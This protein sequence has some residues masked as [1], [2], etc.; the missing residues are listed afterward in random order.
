MHKTN[1]KIFEE[2]LIERPFCERKFFFN[3]HD[4]QGQSTFEHVWLY[5][6]KQIPDKFAVIRICDWAHS[7]RQFQTT[8]G[9]LDKSKNQLISLL[10]VRNFND[11]IKKY[12]NKPW[13]QIWDNL[14]KTYGEVVSKVLSYRLQGLPVPTSYP[15]NQQVINS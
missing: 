13:M 11:V 6:N 8:G 3:D 4:C 12:P 2:L 10:R 9:G 15:D 5:A 1:K 7:T 14:L